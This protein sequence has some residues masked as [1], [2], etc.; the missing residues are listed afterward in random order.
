MSGGTA[1]GILWRTR[2]L[3]ALFAAAQLA[4]CGGGGSGDPAPAPS[5]APAPAPAPGPAPAPLAANAVQVVVD[6]GADGTAFNSPFVSVTVCAP[7]KTTCQTIDH[8][9]VDTGSY[10]LRLTASVLDPALVL[11]LVSTTA[12]AP[13]GECAHFVDGFAWGSVRRADIKLASEV[14]SAI[15]V[16]VVGDTDAAFANVPAACSNTGGNFGSGLGANG[17]LGV[18]L[19]AQ[20]CPTCVASAAPAVYF[21]CSPSGC[22]STAL[23]LASQV[24]NPVVAFPLDNNGVVLTLPPVPQGGVTSLAGSLV[25]GIGTQ[26][27]NQITNETVY[28]TDSRGDIRTTYKGVTMSSFLDSGSNALF[29]ADASIPQCSGFYCPP[30]P[31]SLSAVNTSAIGVSGNVNFTVESIQSLG[32]GV[33]AANVGADA[34]LGRTFDWGLPFFFGRSVFS[35]ISGKPTPKGPG[36]YWA[37]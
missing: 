4:G 10:G 19:F 18:G 5:P 24:T 22:T 37:Y 12:G 25:F 35:A 14:A 2:L 23:P 34:G 16:Q 6:R 29:F 9:L 13:V 30:S 20:D 1:T 21:A 36:P 17:I 7:G 11:P 8:V 3:A 27:N 31:L 15:P 28:V 26:A 33:T 32:S